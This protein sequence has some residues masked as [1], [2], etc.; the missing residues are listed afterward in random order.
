M[1]DSAQTIPGLSNQVLVQVEI[2]RG[3][4]HCYPQRASD[5]LIYK[6]TRGRVPV[7]GRPLEVRWVVTGLRDG[8]FVRLVPKDRGRKTF[9]RQSSFQI[10]P[11]SNTLTSGHPLHGA[12]PGHCFTWRYSIVLSAGERG[13]VLDRLDPGIIIKDYP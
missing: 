1:K 8:Q 7:H 13:K 5:T 2:E 12:G 11:G 10:G 9:A 6:R 3:R 4:I